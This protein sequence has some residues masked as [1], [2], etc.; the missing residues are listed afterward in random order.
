M[1]CI[2]VFSSPSLQLS[3]LFLGSVQ[4]QWRDLGYS[5]GCQLQSVLESF[6]CSSMFSVNGAFL[7]LVCYWLFLHWIGI[8]CTRHELGKGHDLCSEHLPQLPPALNWFESRFAQEL[9]MISLLMASLR[10]VHIS[11]QNEDKTHKKSHG[12]SHNT[13]SVPRF[14]VRSVTSPS[15]NCDL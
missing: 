15:D 9:Q 7:T 6:G 13:N 12:Y 4:K 10:L 2:I 8:I 14:A 5:F 3:K 1:H 11:Q